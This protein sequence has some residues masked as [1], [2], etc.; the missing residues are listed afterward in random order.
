MNVCDDDRTLIQHE[1]GFPMVKKSQF[2][3]GKYRYVFPGQCEQVFYLEVP[4][5]NEWS[6]SIRYD[7][8]GS[9]IEY[10]VE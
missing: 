8:R 5:E 4:G 7:P 6:F 3:A 2:E 9:P 10:T 1:N